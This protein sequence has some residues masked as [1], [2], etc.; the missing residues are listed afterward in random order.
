MFL[1]ISFTTRIIFLDNRF[2]TYNKEFFFEWAVSLKFQETAQHNKDNIYLFVS[3]LAS[4][5]ISI[6]H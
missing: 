2:L 5:T 3:I 4:V 1:N 6:L